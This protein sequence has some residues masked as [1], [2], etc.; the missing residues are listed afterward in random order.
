[1]IVTLFSGTHDDDDG[2]TNHRQNDGEGYVDMQWIAPHLSKTRTGCSRYV[3]SSVPFFLIPLYMQSFSN[4]IHRKDYQF[5]RSDVSRVSVSHC[6]LSSLSCVQYF[7]VAF[8]SSF[9]CR[10][11]PRTTFRNSPCILRPLFPCNVGYRRLAP[12]FRLST[13]RYSE[14]S[15]SKEGTRSADLAN[16]SGAST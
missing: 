9:R 4:R 15:T 2:C 13:W 5:E 1:M 11:S 7:T 14:W 16:T 6:V 3:L 8:H 12:L 10:H